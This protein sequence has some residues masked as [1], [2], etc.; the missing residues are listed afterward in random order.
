MP[1]TDAH[2]YLF[3]HTLSKAEVH[4]CAGFLSF[5]PLQRGGYAER[6][7]YMKYR[8]LFLRRDI[9]MKGRTA[10]ALN[11]TFFPVR[12]SLSP[13]KL[14]ALFLFLFPGMTTKKWIPS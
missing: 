9:V 12:V 5:H 14:L 8:Y 7:L 13:K 6:V 11:E 10:C 1:T 2:M 4:P 3:L